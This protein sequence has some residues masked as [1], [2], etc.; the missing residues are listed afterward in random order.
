MNS[1]EKAILHDWIGR[2]VERISYNLTLGEF[3]KKLTPAIQADNFNIVQELMLPEFCEKITPNNKEEIMFDCVARSV[4]SS[5]IG[6]NFLKY[7]IF[8]YKIVEENSIAKVEVDENIKKMFEAR[9]QNE[10][11]EKE[12]PNHANTTKKVKI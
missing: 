7:L 10:D 11:L 6:E 12:L 1:N 3:T 2:E 4:M 5:G 9:K 8:D